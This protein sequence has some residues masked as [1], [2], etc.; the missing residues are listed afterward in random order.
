MNA[1]AV[2]VTQAT[3]AGARAVMPVTVVASV[4]A[5]AELV[6]PV[7]VAFAVAQ[8][9]SG[10]DPARALLAPIAGVVLSGVL[11]ALRVKLLA[12]L[13]ARQMRALRM[14]V[15]ERLLALSPR[16]VER[17]GVD[18][19]VNL[20]SQYSNEVEAL[21]SAERI[22]RGVAAGTAFGCL[23]LMFAFEWRLAGALLIALALCAVLVSVAI[24]SVQARASA[25]LAALAHTAGDVGEFLR[26]VRSATVYGLRKTYLRRLDDDLKEV[27]LVERDMGNAQA[28]VDLIVKVTLTLSLLGLG[29]LGTVLVAS[30]IT[31]PIQLGGFLG[32]LAIL[33]APVA[34]FAEMM[35]R[36]ARAM[37]A[38]PQL[39]QLAYDAFGSEQQEDVTPAATAYLTVHDV[40]LVPAP[41][42]RIGPVSFT[43]AAGELIC[44]AG[45][46]GSGKTTLLS[47]L[48]GF[49]P[50]ESGEVT[51]NGK[52][53]SEWM[54]AA[55][56]RNIAFVEQGTP[57]VGATVRE[58]LSPDGPLMDDEAALS[59]LH[60]MGLGDRLSTAGLDTALERT[61]TTLSG[62]ERQR[63]SLARA[64]CSDRPIMLLDEPTSNLDARTEVGV[65]ELLD[66]VRVGRTVIVASHSERVLERADTVVNLPNPVAE[67]LPVYTGTEEAEEVLVTA[68]G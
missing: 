55:L 30:G 28:A 10:V 25:G 1:P 66:E 26:S 48:A 56:W 7:A 35:Q 31:T 13:A 2:S 33:L 65:L 36:R 18:E 43:A 3:R 37:A 46:S 49:L 27:E 8:V 42:I 60:R 22:R 5:L 41:D 16:T 59:I 51:V 40:V 9:M 29:V 58:F 53:L 50:P 20:L 12:R 19:G 64:F 62:G 17:L 39:E 52:K 68:K 24:R 6:V 4:S 67:S 44:V 21:L 57:I 47:A 32:A 63:L 23:V 38:L 54:P 61:G 11:A 15:A 45:H 34:Q 14:G